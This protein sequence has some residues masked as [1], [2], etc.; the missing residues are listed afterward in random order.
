M[1]MESIKKDV[2][3]F[4]WI[5][6]V[7]QV[8]DPHYFW[9]Q[10]G[11]RENL[12]QFEQL[13]KDMQ[14]FVYQGW[15]SASRI[16]DLE[17]GTVVLVKSDSEKGTCLKRGQ[18][19]RVMQGDSVDVFYVDYGNT[20]LKA[21]DKICINVPAKFKLCPPQAV[22]CSLA[23]VKPLVKSWTSRGIKTFQQFTG[24]KLLNVLVLYGEPGYYEVAL[25]PSD[26]DNG[27]SVG[28]SLVTEEVA[29]MV[30]EQMVPEFLQDIPSFMTQS[31][32]SSP[33]GGVN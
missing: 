1:K 19:A 30:E 31:Y 14:A 5:G 24:N 29:M 26:E 28:H 21:I 22:R 7:C 17:P 11:T 3:E 8:I 10:L 12:L 33:P 15:S 6:R 25:Y 2:C 4:V 16:D 20:E 9:M 32:L 27:R 13:Q 18:V 23:G